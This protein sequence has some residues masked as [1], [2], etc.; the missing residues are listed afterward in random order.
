MFK[1]LKLNKLKNAE[2]TPLHFW[3]SITFSE[4]M[5]YNNSKE[6]KMRNLNGD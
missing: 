5:C 3:L 4:F 2:D 1:I 6:E